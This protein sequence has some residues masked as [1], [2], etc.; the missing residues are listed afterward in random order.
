MAYKL[1]RAQSH[2]IELDV[3]G[4]IITVTVGGMNLYKKVLEAQGKLKD[5]QTKID[6]LSRNKIEITQ[7]L[8]EFLGQT[9]LYFFGVVFGEKNTERILEFYDGNYDEMLMKV[10]PF[11]IREFIPA[12]KA[13]AET[14]SKAYAKRLA[15]VS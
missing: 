10:Y 15:G 11:I 5:V 8:V 2:V 4:E 9:I 6:T 14:E 7:E 13:N 1:E 12:L 3:G